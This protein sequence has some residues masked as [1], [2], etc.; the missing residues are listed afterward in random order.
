MLLPADAT[1]KRLVFTDFGTP[2][3]RPAPP[4]G[5]VVAAAQTSVNMNIQPNTFHF[6]RAPYLRRPNFTL[7]EDPIV[8]V[9]LNTA[10]MWVA[11]WV[12]SRPVTFQT[13]VLNHEQGHYE[14]SML[15][16]VDVFHEL[17]EISGGAF[18][19][20][21]AGAGAIRRMQARLFKVQAIHNKYDRD[22]NHGLNLMMQTAWDNALRTAR[23]TFVRSSLRTA[24]QNAG[25]FP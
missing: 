12:F 19:S 14:I 16:A 5:A 21:L 18:A 7:V 3:T 1:F 2:L 25:L 9:T 15:N 6:Q 13:S 10:Q 4:P 17:L 8:T 24:L 22:T 23:V 11:S 20:E